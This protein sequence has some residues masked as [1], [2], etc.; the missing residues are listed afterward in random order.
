MEALDGLTAGV[1]LIETALQA[2]VLMSKFSTHRQCSIH[3]TNFSDHYVLANPGMYVCRGCCVDTFPHRIFP[4]SSG[5]AVFLKKS[6]TG[7]GFFGV[8]TFDLFDTSTQKTT[9][10]MA[11]LFK[12]PHNIDISSEYAVGVVDFGRLCDK[13]LFKEMMEG[14][15]VACV[16][17]D[18]KGSSLTLRNQQFSIRAMML[19]GLSPVMKVHVSTN[20]EI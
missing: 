7:R 2:G 19:D 4:S 11:V 12:V 3:V 16:K 5:S 8:V 17:G 1:E 14:T 18:S 13:S 15:N 20:E 6:F 10:Q 9:E